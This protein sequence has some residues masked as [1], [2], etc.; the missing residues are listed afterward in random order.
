MESITRQDANLL[1]REVEE[2]LRQVAERHG[3]QLDIR[4]GTF[5]SG[6]FKPRVEFKTAASD[7]DEFAR[8]ATLYGLNADDFG[9]SFR[10]GGREFTVAGISPRSP[11]RPILAKSADGRTWKFPADAVVRA[12][13]A[14]FTMPATQAAAPATS[15]PK[16]ALVKDG[17]TL[18]TSSSKASLQSYRSKNK[19]GGDIV[20]VA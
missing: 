3:L 10:N 9:R 11:R 14:G 4:G 7:R 20:Q 2:A 15:A 18:K 17:E 5:D 12:L 19:C 16:F 1:G 13:G 6:S 8:Y